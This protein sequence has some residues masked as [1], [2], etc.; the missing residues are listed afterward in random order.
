[1]ERILVKEYEYTCGDGCC[2][3]HGYDVTI[4]DKGDVFEYLGQVDPLDAILE[5]LNLQIE[6]KE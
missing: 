2:Y 3:E 6:W 5:H 1:M 4:Y